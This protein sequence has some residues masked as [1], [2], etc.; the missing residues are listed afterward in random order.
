M[1]SFFT[2]FVFLFKF[3]LTKSKTLSLKAIIKELD[4]L[5]KTF[6]IQ[7][8]AR[9]KTIV[10]AKKLIEKMPDPCNAQEHYQ[11]FIRKKQ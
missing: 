5:K 8:N 3:E 1:R 11:S 2:F 6:L 7:W 10:L 9:K 4:F